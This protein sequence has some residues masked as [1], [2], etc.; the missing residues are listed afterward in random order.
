[1]TIELQDLRWALVVSQHRSLRQAADTL[2]IRQSTV[3]RR[4]RDLEHRVGTKLFERTNGGTRP[5]P[6]GHEFIATAR[7]IIEATDAAF[8]QLRTR[9]IG[10]SGRLTIGIYA[11][12][13]TGNLRATLLEYRRR[14]PEVLLHIIDGN[15]D[16]LLCALNA[17][18]ADIAIMT[19]CRF[20]WGDRTLPLWSERVIVA[21]PER[22]PLTTRRFIN[23]ADLANEPVLLPLHGPGPE[24]E[25]LFANKLDQ[26]GPQRILHQDVGLDRLLSLVGVEYG[27]L[28]MLEGATGARYDGVAYREVHED[29]GPAR[30]NFA[31]YW[32]K[33][34]ANPTLGPFLSMLYERYPDLSGALAP[35]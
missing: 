24:L 25:H 16:R 30:L 32:R 5:T 35:G 1:M 11:S 19:T 13:S 29:D 33:D 9:C 26:F 22:H 18:T 31:A 8:A 17:N 6:A 2:N 23:W 27:A 10:E 3:S 15:R 12:L 21:V 28:L 14:F 34:N 4:L 7:R 20:G